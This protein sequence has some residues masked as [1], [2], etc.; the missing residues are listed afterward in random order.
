MY[1][2]DLRL[3]FGQ[4]D[5]LW[6]EIYVFFRERSEIYV[7]FFGLVAMHVQSLELLGLRGVSFSIG[8]LNQRWSGVSDQADAELAMVWS[9]PW[10]GTYGLP[11]YSIDVYRIM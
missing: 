10:S 5:S 9:R 2:I 6:S 11:Y 3:F 4:L 1:V 7:S 8:P